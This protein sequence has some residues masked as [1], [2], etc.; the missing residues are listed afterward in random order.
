M[1][2]AQI[3]HA[4]AELPS[5]EQTALAAWIVERDRVR[6]DK[7]IE[8]DFSPGGAGMALLERVKKKV[9]EGLSRPLSDGRPNQ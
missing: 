9:G 7:E 1:D 8:R 4:I 3:Q 2:L 5:E 6:W